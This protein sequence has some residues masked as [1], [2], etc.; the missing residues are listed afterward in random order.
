MRRRSSSR[1]SLLPR[2]RGA[3]RLARTGALLLLVLARA[4]PLPAVEAP[5]YWSPAAYPRVDGSRETEPLGMQIACVA[6]GVE[7]RWTAHRGGERRLL[8]ADV[9]DE[10][11][12]DATAWLLEN[13]RHTGTVPAYRKL[14]T[15]EADLVLVRRRPN[16]DELALAQAGEIALDVR[17]LAL[18]AVVFLVH[19]ENPVADL[20]ADEL[21]AL[22][23]GRIANWG[24]VGGRYGPVRLV[25]RPDGAPE[26]ALLRRRL[27]S[28]AV[29]SGAAGAAV[30]LAMRR[31][32]VARLVG[33][34]PGAIGYG[35]YVYERFVRAG[36]SVR[37]LAVDGVP[38]EPETIRAGRYP[39]A[40]PVFLVTREG[41]HP[42]SSAGLLRRWLLSG[43]GQ[44]AVLESGFV[45]LPEY[46][47]LD[48]RAP[49]R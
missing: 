16:A 6:L 48:R 9:H 20:S 45:P 3:A 28:P 13:I 49:G 18:D 11:P 33:A 15:R 40:E 29:A 38:P 17:P 41:T 44:D 31:A 23:S 7:T 19:E 46:L 5:A 8:P 12:S 35:T 1:L 24:G 10:A 25:V 43:G 14:L 37:L 27:G 42:D 2:A 4:A 39:Y 47:W 36:E 21:R 34:D 22:L 30:R 26:E 32:E